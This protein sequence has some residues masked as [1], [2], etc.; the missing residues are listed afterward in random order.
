MPS[1]SRVTRERLARDLMVACFFF[2]GFTA[3]LYQTVWLRLALARF[4]V[5]TSIAATVLAVF[6]LGLAAGSAVAARLLDRADAR[7]GLGPLWVYALA[8]SVVCLGGLAVPGLL[9]AG[10]SAL[11]AAGPTD[12]ILYTLSSGVI[13]TTILLPFCTAMGLTFPA[14]VAFLTSVEAGGERGFPFSA[15]Y[16]ANVAGALLGAVITPVVLIEWYGFLATTRGAAAINGGIAA[17]ALAAFSGQPLFH[18][19]RA[20]KTA[21][22]ASPSPESRARML[23]LFV[24]GFTTM[25]MEVVWMRIYPFVVG[26]FVYSF[27]SI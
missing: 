17:A 4:G 23:A 12:G 11:L 20:T 16:L 18:G 27:A 22:G 2:S 10:R 26:T 14:A 8:E 19:A 13:L 5:N 21:P 25:G 24:T 1:A 7:L 15:L 6:M 3:L 9:S